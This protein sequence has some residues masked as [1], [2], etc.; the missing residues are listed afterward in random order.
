[1][2]AG[3]SSGEGLRCLSASEERIGMD[4][5]GTT[6]ASD[7]AVLASEDWRKARAF[8]LALRSALLIASESEVDVITMIATRQAVE[9]TRFGEIVF[10]APSQ[11]H[12]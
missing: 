1:M 4:N 3:F 7:I 9:K 12:T 11:S 6:S 8:R 10:E 2:K 5:A